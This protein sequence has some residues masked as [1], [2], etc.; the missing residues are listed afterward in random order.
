MCLGVFDG[1]LAVLADQ[2]A[3]DGQQPGGQIE[4]YPDEAEQLAASRR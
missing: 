3:P 1:H 4:V 2:V